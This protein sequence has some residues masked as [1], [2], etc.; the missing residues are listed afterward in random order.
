MTLREL[1]IMFNLRSN[2]QKNLAD[3][4]IENFS[5]QS[6]FAVYRYMR[7]KKFHDDIAIAS[8]D[9]QYYMSQGSEHFKLKF[10]NEVNKE[11]KETA[12]MVF[13]EPYVDSFEDLFRDS[14]HINQ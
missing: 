1:L 11:K 12:L 8:S 5:N 14:I 9:I 4:Q 10:I 7:S 3:L 2:H 6:M 13:K